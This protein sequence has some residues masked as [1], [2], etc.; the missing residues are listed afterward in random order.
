MSAL[1]TR[2]LKVKI[3]SIDY[4]A[5]ASKVSLSA[6]DTDADFITFQDAASGGSKTHTLNFTAAQDMGPGSLW[7][8]QLLSAGATIPVLV[9]PYGVTTASDTTPF[10]SGSVVIPKFDGDYLGG[11]AD[12]SSTAK[13]TFDGAWDF[14]ADPVL[15]TSGTF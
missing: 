2:L 5:N 11:D 14:T 1:G 10:Y 13:F 9:N 3:N 15:V 7:R 8:L 12:K 6:A 4:T